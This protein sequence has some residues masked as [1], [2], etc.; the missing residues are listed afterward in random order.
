[1]LNEKPNNDF[2]WQSKLEEIESLPGEVFN[3]E[4]AWG[5]LHQRM[6]GT[7][8]NKK[9]VWYWVAAACLLLAVCIPWLFLAN[10]KEG[11]LVKN[12][13]VPKQ[14]QS[15]PSHL[16]PPRNNETVTV[17][18]VLPAEKKLPEPSYKKSDKIKPSFNHAII[19]PSIVQDK[20]EK[21]QFITQKITNN[22][23]EP[24]EPAINIEAASPGKKKLQVVHINELGDRVTESPNIA[25]SYERHPLQV[26]FIN[27]ELETNPPSFGNTG[28]NIFKPKP[29][30]SN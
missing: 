16:L 1:M 3:K 9:M 6:R 25:R 21:E 22:A 12:I 4:A 15:S 2:H 13:P 5:K 17:T 7:S 14:I 10:K 26:K 30:P 20:K 28:F 27:Q 18:S 8:R 11:I 24:V 23:T 19:T 29:T